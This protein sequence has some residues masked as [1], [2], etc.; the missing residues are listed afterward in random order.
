[1]SE[2]T[3]VVSEDGDLLEAYRIVVALGA[4]DEVTRRECSDIGIHI[5]AKWSPLRPIV[6]WLT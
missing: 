3:L 2:I 5:R 6:V 4:R 1:M